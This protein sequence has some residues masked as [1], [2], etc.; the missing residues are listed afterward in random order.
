MDESDLAWKTDAP[1]W[2]M[3]WLSACFRNCIRLGREFDIVV[4]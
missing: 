1:K 4:D 2:D 3:A